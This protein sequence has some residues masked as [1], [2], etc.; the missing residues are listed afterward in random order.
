MARELAAAGRL[1]C[2]YSGYPLWKLPHSEA[3][4][5][6]T[7]SFRTTVVYGLQRLLPVWARP[8]PWMLYGW[9]DRGFD[10][11]VGRVLAQSDFIHAM[12]G[13]CLKTF[14]RARELG[15][16]T[17]LNHASS[18]IREWVRIMEP[19]YGRVGL[20]LSEACPYDSA[21]FES[22]DREYSLA[23]YHCVASTLG[24]DY[25][26]ALGIAAERIW[27]VP[28]AADPEIFFPRPDG[29]VVPGFRIVFP[30]QV[31][32]R[33]GIKTLLDALT[34]AAREDWRVDFFGAVVPEA[35]HDLASYRGKPRL[36][37]HGAVSQSLLAEAFRGASVLALP[38][39]EEGFS[40]VVPQALNCG[41]P[42]ITT[43]R[44]GAKDLIRQ[45]ENG[46]VVPVQDS[47]AL[48]RELIWWERNPSRPKEIFLWSDAARRLLTLSS[49]AL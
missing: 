41:L 43:D 11:W 24:R 32:L 45:H 5:I 22:A 34:L 6:R 14:Q 17:V 46:S 49:N 30:G 27:V 16:A 1:G 28:Y 23:D 35:T 38:S 47:E 44:N 15:V 25:L 40:L 37:F 36:H 4:R 42:C 31:G 7:H 29:P 18:P 8:D 33:K 13:Q 12:P 9:Q 20:R 26:V 3:A 19:E 10:R 2:Y 21:Y 48:L 39:L